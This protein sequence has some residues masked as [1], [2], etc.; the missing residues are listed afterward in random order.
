MRKKTDTVVNKGAKVD[1]SK[2]MTKKNRVTDVSPTE[3][4]LDFPD[5]A[6]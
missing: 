2:K 6:D 4:K 3:S 1:P 5:T